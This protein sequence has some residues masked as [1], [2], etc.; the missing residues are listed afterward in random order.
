MGKSP[1]VPQVVQITLIKKQEHSNRGPVRQ[2]PISLHPVYL[3]NERP[4][5]HKWKRGRN[6]LN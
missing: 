5:I 1:L 6:C 2:A 3:T 4:R